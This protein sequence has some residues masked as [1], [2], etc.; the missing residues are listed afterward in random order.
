MYEQLETDVLVVGGGATGLR[1]AIQAA[2]RGRRVILL[3]KGP[4]SRSGI[5]PLASTGITASFHPEDSP[6][7]HYSDTMR[8]SRGLADAPLVRV[9]A[10][11]APKQVKWL[12]STGQRFSTNEDGSL[13]LT[14]RPGQTH[15]RNCYA[16]GG[17]WSMS[18]SLFM[19]TADYPQLRIVQHAYVLRLVVWDG[20]VRGAV[21]LDL[22]SGA[23]KVVQA[24]ATVLATGGYGQLWA[25]SDCPPDSTGDGAI[26]ALDAGATLVDLEMAQFYPAVGVY[27]PA[28]R[29]L[30]MVP[31]EFG[32]NPELLGG[33]LL[34]GAGEEFVQGF[35]MRDELARAIFLEIEE[36]RASSHGGVYLDLVHSKYPK[37]ELTRRIRKYIPA[38]NAHMLR[39]G[40]DIT[41]RMIEVAPAPHFCCGGIRIDDR[42]STGVPGL[43]A[44]GECSGNVQGANRISGNALAE[45]LVFGSQA[46]NAAA[47]F[48]GPSTKTKV[49]AT[50][51][52]RAEEDQI[53]SMMARGNGDLRPSEFKS[54]IQQV[55]WRACSPK[56]NG[57]ALR[58]ALT[59]IADMKGGAERLATHD[60]LRGCHEIQQ[61]YEVRAMAR[62]SE[63]LL[64]AA[65]SRE[66]SRGAHYREDFPTSKDVA[67]HTAVTWGAG[68]VRVGTTPV[69]R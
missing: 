33:R 28:V 63:C 54:Q 26:L 18:R 41:E 48:A 35:P 29:G 31:Y 4:I 67:A 47:E 49:D 19:K 24:G 64:L 14:I 34:N 60:V 5:T 7:I 39:L 51:I 37:E 21:Y 2:E 38:Q 56:R 3:A 69:L 8:G 43:F 10:D 32:I 15:P 57:S 50:S 30:I 42:C 61:A 65:L 58:D 27:P 12:A 1:A 53:R 45:T 52:V 46:G 9:L 44:A 22:K 59:A 23:L 16:I 11:E 62:L 55:I 20:E 40:I 36:G 6:E 13:A 68:G 66:E 25:V 17:G